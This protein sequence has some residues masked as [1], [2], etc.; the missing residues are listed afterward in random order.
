L[1]RPAG[2][3]ARAARLAVALAALA[4][5]AAAAM[6]MRVDAERLVLAG[7]VLADDHQ[8]LYAALAAAGPPVT[9]IHL[10]D[11]PGGVLAA[12]LLMGQLIRDRGLFTIASGICAS[13]C[14]LAF[15]GGRERFFADDRPAAR[16]ALGF[17]GTYRADT[18]ALVPELAPVV[19][20][21]VQDQTGG[22]TTP[23]LLE[24]WSKLGDPRELVYFFHPEAAASL[25]GA[26]VVLC[27]PGQRDAAGRTRFETCERIEHTDAL[28]QGIVTSTRL[29]RVA[30]A[31]R[32]GPAPAR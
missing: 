31:A 5:P 10:R 32:T 13:S 6:E 28:R 11:S 19:E 9:A 23:R 26:S 1:T 22:R 7:P 3:A 2:P 18:R 16:S 15:L 14:A 17:H 21:Y 27:G 24:R 29:Y 12:G 25:G 30:P 20:R 8:R 4:A